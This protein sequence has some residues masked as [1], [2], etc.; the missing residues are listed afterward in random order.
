LRLSI[1]SGVQENVVGDPVEL[2]VGD[3]VLVEPSTSQSPQT[4]PTPFAKMK[5]ANR[6]NK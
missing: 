1:L 2:V 6:I 5:E 3:D 4:V